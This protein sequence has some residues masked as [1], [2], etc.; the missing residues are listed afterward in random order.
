LWS[1]N[2]L[3]EF[4]P[5]GMIV[6]G[7]GFL[8][9][10][11][12]VTQ[13]ERWEENSG[14]SPSTLAATIAALLCASIMSRARGDVETAAFLE[15]HADFLE[16]NIERWMVTESG[17][18]VP[19]ITRHYIRITPAWIGDPL[20]DDGPGERTL[21]IA[22]RPPGTQY[23]FQARDIVDAG[24]LQLVRF[25]IRRADD[26]IIVDSLR[27]VD[28]V[29]KV[30]TPF[31]VTWRRY[32]HDGYGEGPDG[33]PYEGYGQGRAWPLLTGERGHYELQAGRDPGPYI[34]SMEGFAT[35]TRLLPE[36]VW[37]QESSPTP[38]LRLGRPTASATPLMW[39]HAEY[40]KLL[41]SAL[42]NAVFDLIPE[43]AERYCGPRGPRR[44]IHVWSFLYPAL[45]VGA[46]T[47]LRIIADDEFLL[48]WS[49]DGWGT[50]T[51]TESRTNL[52]GVHYAD[53]ETAPE[54]RGGD[55]VFTFRWA[56][57]QRW[58]G[59]DFR[60]AVV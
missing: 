17:R 35:P 23:E 33:E 49:R 18:L 21:V 45:R 57:G 43:V 2:A 22:N 39:A 6:Q 10:R 52:L 40:L 44:R 38:F 50:A 16:A 56:A 4:N 53:I 28:A 12:P 37:D 27:V 41:R 55:I 54:A 48:H 19:G 59:R 3:G 30:D 32:N 42:D 1:H 58:E 25:G 36:Q 29:L 13:Q 60:V 9:K 51:D 26:P 14:Y 15:E 34:R 31:G 46:G 5:F 20:P 8:V 7:A 47:T 24:F 11:G